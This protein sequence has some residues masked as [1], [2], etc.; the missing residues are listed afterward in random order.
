MIMGV[1]SNICKLKFDN[2]GKHNIEINKVN[3]RI[4]YSKSKIF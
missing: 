3:W 1:L 4:D 2:I